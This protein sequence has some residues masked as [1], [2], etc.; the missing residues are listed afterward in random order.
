MR[1]NV[2]KMSKE[3]RDITAQHFAGAVLDP[4]F[5]D[6]VFHGKYDT[7]PFC[8]LTRR[9]WSVDVEKGCLVFDPQNGQP[10]QYVASND[11]LP[12]SWSN[13]CVAHKKGLNPIF[14]HFHDD[15][16][17]NKAALTT[18]FLQAWKA[19]ITSS[20][21]TV[22]Y[23]SLRAHFLNGDQNIDSG[24]ENDLYVRDWLHNMDEIDR[25]YFVNDDGDRFYF[26][27]EFIKTSLLDSYVTFIYL[28]E[29]WLF[30]DSQREYKVLDY[31]KLW[32]EHYGFKSPNSFKARLH[33]RF[34]NLDYLKDTDGS[35]KL[36]F[37]KPFGFA[38]KLV[39]SR[40]GTKKD[41]EA[42]LTMCTS[43]QVRKHFL[44][45][46]ESYSEIIQLGEPST[47]YVW[48]LFP[49][50]FALKRYDENNHP[51]EAES[52]FF[53]MNVPEWVS[54]S[55][56]LFTEVGS[57]AINAAGAEKAVRDEAIKRAF[58]L[59]GKGEIDPFFHN[60]A[61]WR[62]G[63][64]KEKVWLT[65]PYSWPSNV[66]PILD[67]DNK[68][69]FV[70]KET[71]E[72][73]RFLNYNE[74]IVKYKN[75]PKWPYH[76]IYGTSDGVRDFLL[77]QYAVIERAVRQYE[78]QDAAYLISHGPV[79]N[80]EYLLH[81][82]PYLFTPA[83][84]LLGLVLFEFWVLQMLDN[85][86]V[87][88]Q[89]SYARL[90]L[91]DLPPDA[92]MD[93]VFQARGMT[94][95]EMDSEYISGNQFQ[96]THQLYD[97]LFPYVLDNTKISDPRLN[98]ELT[99]DQQKFVLNELFL[100][101]NRM[102]GIQFNGVEEEL[103]IDK[104]REN[105]LA[106]IQSLRNVERTVVRKCT[107][108]W[109][110]GPHYYYNVPLSAVG[111][112]LK[113]RVKAE[114]VKQWALGRHTS[115]IFDMV[116]TGNATPIE[117]N[118]N[119]CAVTRVTTYEE[120]H[121]LFDA[122]NT[123]RPVA[124]QTQTRSN[125]RHTS[126]EF[127]FNFTNFEIRLVKSGKCTVPGMGEEVVDSV[128][129]KIDLRLFPHARVIGPP[130]MFQAPGMW[131]FVNT[132]LR[133]PRN[134]GVAS[135]LI[136]DRRTNDSCLLFAFGN[137]KYIFVPHT[138][139]QGDKF[140]LR[141]IKPHEQNDYDVLQLIRQSGGFADISRGNNRFFMRAFTTTQNRAHYEPIADEKVASDRYYASYD[142]QRRMAHSFY[143]GSTRGAKS[144]CIGGFVQIKHSTSV[145]G[146]DVTS[147]GMDGTGLPTAI[148]RRLALIRT[149]GGG[150]ATHGINGLWQCWYCN[151]RRETVANID[152][153]D[154]ELFSF[155]SMHQVLPS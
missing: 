49:M 73:I 121:E 25:S 34:D 72:P 66:L 107:S 127:D 116:F 125:E 126:R 150:D 16:L 43:T 44:K 113:V 85:P 14:R 123:N 147:S 92:E 76:C 2:S 84:P 146:K 80:Q 134:T 152:E 117:V 124:H 93:D 128:K 56:E 99:E 155:S 24:K 83:E 20:D 70:D 60:M 63:L 132:F 106:K 12:D 86:D 62:I 133:F 105:L 32:V 10:K 61:Q 79:E 55:T 143:D 145:P 81:H 122:N 46:V 35:L 130:Q 90:N 5:Y 45:E 40:D 96:Y 6:Q 37:S 59:P 26:T 48:E 31:T 101:Q 109:D 1:D 75:T 38:E 71:G 114:H 111:D 7:V 13:F 138:N 119:N 100:L 91:D 82:R 67:E 112:N 50:H 57:W 97:G 151:Q 28:Y 103:S 139:V 65:E 78:E 21:P 74:D 9:A 36:P 110:R 144:E 95:E 8:K 42:K 33:E 88:K 104:Q 102:E 64:R 141:Q 118:A 129:H 120:M 47:P 30:M 29:P 135:M 137:M 131:G 27:E 39:F 87:M 89:V 54:I 136:K 108:D 51:V 58:K 52:M 68:P 98:E 23:E 154:G 15:Y 41:F 3:R 115:C 17:Q 94:S 140:T 77:A 22:S 18:E 53:Y 69:I 153:R 11:K 4:A 19:A 142:G 148:S 149:P